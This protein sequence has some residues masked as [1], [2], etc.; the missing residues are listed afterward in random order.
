MVTNEVKLLRGVGFALAVVTDISILGAMFYHM[1]PTR[2]PGM[3]V[4]NG[5]YEKLVVYGFNRGT[6]FTYVFCLSALLSLY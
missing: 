2:N 5:W 6:A 1:Q 3:A 4:P